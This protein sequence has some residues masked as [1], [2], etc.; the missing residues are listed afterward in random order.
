M[1]TDIGAMKVFA[2]APWNVMLNVRSVALE[3]VLAVAVLP[4]P[5]V[6]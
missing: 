2:S 3:A 4:A 5:S 1:L 6:A